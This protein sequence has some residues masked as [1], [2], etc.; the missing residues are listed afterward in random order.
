MTRLLAR[1]WKVDNQNTCVIMS[2]Q[3]TFIIYKTTWKIKTLAL[4]FLYKD[5]FWHS[6]LHYY[7]IGLGYGHQISPHFS[8]AYPTLLGGK[9]NTAALQTAWY[10]TSNFVPN[11]Y[12]FLLHTH[13]T[14]PTQ[15]PAGKSVTQTELCC[16]NYTLDHPQKIMKLTV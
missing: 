16:G 5:L 2:V 10:V 14:D 12:N 15:C 13:M 7:T 8:F 9:S 11:I 6:A 3:R 1:S 4:I